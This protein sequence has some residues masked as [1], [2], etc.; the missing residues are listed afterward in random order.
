MEEHEFTDKFMKNRYI[1]NKGYYIKDDLSSFLLYFDYFSQGL[2]LPKFVS[3]TYIRKIAHTLLRI[4]LIFSYISK[5]YRLNYPLIALRDNAIIII[6]GRGKWGSRIRLVKINGKFKIIK[7]VQSKQIYLKEKKFYTAYQNN[8]ANIKLPKHVFKKNNIIEMEFL[9]LKTFQRLIL[10]GSFS[11]KKSLVHFDMIKKQIKLLYET[12]SLVHGDLWPGNIFIDGKTYYLIDFSD[13][14]TNKLKYDLY[15][16]LYSIL[17]SYHYIKI[18]EK[19]IAE[20]TANKISVSK[21]LE[22][23]NEELEYIEEQFIQYRN[24][25]FPGVYYA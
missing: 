22:A 2:T 25:R 16:L 13:S 11:L 24:T 21:L 3:N 1:I 19:T 20:Y 15:T 7:R 6:N 5:L 9:R 18:N 23:N 10:E 14:H 8:A 17:S 12:E 4:I